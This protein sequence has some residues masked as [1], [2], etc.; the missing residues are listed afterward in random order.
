MH[1]LGGTCCVEGY[2]CNPSGNGCVPGTPPT[3]TPGGH[4]PTNTP[5]TNVGECSAV[6]I[7]KGGAAVTPSSLDPGDAVKLAV[8]GSNGPTKAHFRMNGVQLP[9][10]TDTDPNWTETTTKNSAGEFVVNYTIPTT[11]VTDFV[12]EAEVFVDGVWK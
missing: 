11:G 2:V 3:H 5:S 8:S 4:N 12:M 9:G 1:G 10:D 7:Y 6:K